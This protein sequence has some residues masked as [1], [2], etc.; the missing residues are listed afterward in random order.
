VVIVGGTGDELMVNE[1]DCWTVCT[2]DEESL[3]EKVCEE[4]PCAVG[5]PVIAPVVWS[6]E[7]LAG[8]AGVT[9]QLYGVTPPDPP[10]VV[11]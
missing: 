2:G 9:D 8:S 5:M 1:R 7:R 10:T 11:A 6:N 3:S 4:V